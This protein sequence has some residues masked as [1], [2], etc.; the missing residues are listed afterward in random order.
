MKSAKLP[1]TKIIHL[2]EL[3]NIAKLT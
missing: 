2:C 3:N 1:K